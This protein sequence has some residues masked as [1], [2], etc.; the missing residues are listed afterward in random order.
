MNLFKP[1]IYAT[2]WQINL[3]KGVINMSN[4][5]KCSNIYLI[6]F[7]SLLF[8]MQPTHVFASKT[9]S[10]VKSTSKKFSKD[11]RSKSRDKKSRDKKSRDKKSGDKKP[12]KRGPEKV[13]NRRN[14]PTKKGGGKK[15]SNSRNESRRKD[16]IESETPYSYRLQEFD[17]LADAIDH[18]SDP[19]YQESLP[20]D[21]HYEQMRESGKVYI[22]DY[23]SGSIF[24][25][26]IAS[27]ETRF[28]NP[29]EYR[30]LD[31]VPFHPEERE[32]MED[33]PSNVQGIFKGGDQLLF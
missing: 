8:V 17:N 24:E 30:D 10:S 15:S 23:D 18:L 3:Q 33:R 25:H 1:P 31:I 2:T 5:R 4:P 7:I 11:S 32:D 19:S 6:F 9:K 21:P 22:E 28:V 16:S 26:D 12:K 27:G 29:D 13:T 14:R 20:N